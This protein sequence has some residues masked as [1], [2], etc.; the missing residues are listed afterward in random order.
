MSADEKFGMSILSWATG[1]SRPKIRQVLDLV[2][3]METLERIDVQLRRQ[4]NRRRAS[5]ELHDGRLHRLSPCS[6][7][8]VMSRAEK[9]ATCGKYQDRA[10]RR[11]PEQY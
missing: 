11:G 2:R 7:V 4:Q 6:I 9:R 5:A 8:P 10:R 1:V 3:E